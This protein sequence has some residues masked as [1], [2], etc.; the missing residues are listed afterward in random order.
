MSEAYEKSQQIKGRAD[1]EAARIYAEA[2]GRDPEFYSFLKSLETYRKTMDKNTYL[3]ISTDAE[4]LKY[5]KGIIS[6]EDK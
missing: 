4:F 5:L 6:F 1:A 2:Y 3:I